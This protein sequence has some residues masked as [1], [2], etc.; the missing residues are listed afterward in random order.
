MSRTHLRE[1]RAVDP[2]DVVR[3][4]R[5]VGAV[6]DTVVQV[7]FVAPP[8]RE[9][10]KQ[11]LWL[12]RSAGAKYP[13]HAAQIVDYSQSMHTA[14]SREQRADAHELVQ[15]LSFT[16]SSPIQPTLLRHHFT[17]EYVHFEPDEGL[18]QLD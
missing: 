9:H 3:Q 15:S 2:G 16:A 10:R 18:E 5:Q 4:D 13:F 17:G 11:P 7:M 8:S 14:G 6:G 12:A 1:A